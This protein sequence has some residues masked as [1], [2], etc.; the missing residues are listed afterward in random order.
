M[1]ISRKKGVDTDSLSKWGLEQLLVGLKEGLVVD[2]TLSDFRR[3]VELYHRIRLPDLP[4]KGEGGSM[5][6]GVR[7]DKELK[8]ELRRP[9]HRAFPGQQPSTSGAELYRELQRLERNGERA[10]VVY[11]TENR[12]ADVILL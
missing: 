10:V 3:A 8:I 4:N 9:D 2:F 6:H 7:F 11:S 12:A 5:P 1:N